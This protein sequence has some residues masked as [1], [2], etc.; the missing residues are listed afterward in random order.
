MKD[1][2][3]FTLL[4]FPQSYDGGTQLNLRLVV[5]PRNQN[6]LRPAIEPV[7][8]GVVP[9]A[10]AQFS[11]AAQII[12]GLNNFPYDQLTHA[13]R[14]LPIVVP[15]IA[16]DLFLALK[17]N[18]KISD[19]DRGNDALETGVKATEAKPPE[20][21]PIMKYLPLSYRQAFNFTTPRIRNAV[22]DDSY[23]CAVRDAAPV[24]GFKRSEDKISWGKVFA[25]ALRQRLLA[26][27]LGMVYDTNV[28]I[29]AADF[30][31]GGWIYVDL[32]A[33]S[34]YRAR[35]QSHPWFIRRY[36]ARIP[37]LK[38]NDDRQIFAPLLFPV[39]FKENPGDPDPDPDGNYDELFIEAA[40]YDDG[41]AKIV[42]ARQPHSRDLLAE[43][44]DGAHPVKDI[45]IR[46][47]WDDEQI[48]I[49]YLR[50]L[51][52]DPSVK[53]PT[54][55]L[56]APLGVFGY[57]VDAREV[58]DPSN[59]WNSLNAVVSKQALVVNTQNDQIPLGDFVGELPYQVYPAQLD[60]N[61]NKSF[62]LPMYFA[63]WNGNSMVLPDEDAANIYHTND[64]VEADPHT[65]VT[66]KAENRLN[67]IYNPGPVDAELKYG[68]LYEFRV[69][70]RDLSGG[71]PEIGAE[72]RNKTPSNT[73]ERRFRRYV[74]PNQPRIADLAANTD[75][76]SQVDELNIRRPL[77]GYPA[78]V[79][80]DGY[81][82]PVAK[83]IAASNAALAARTGHAFGIADP[84]VNRVQVTVE[85][86]TLK[87]DNLLSV[88]G[89]ENYVNLYTTNCFFPPVNNE[90]DF[91]AELNIPIVYRDCPV[92]HT[93]E[94]DKNL[95]VD[96]GLPANI[97]SMAQIVV[98]KGRTIRLTVRAVCEDKPV[99][100]NYYGLLQN[101]DDVK[102]EKDVR[103]GP[104][105]QIMTYK[106][107]E[108]EEDL[109]LDVAGVP[110]L[111]G[112]FMQPDPPQ[113]FDGT[114]VS[115]L[116]GHQ[117][118][119]PPDMIERL[120]KQL[121]LESR[122]LTLTGQK[123]ERVQFGCS[124][125]IRH[126]LSPE[127]SSLTF[128]SKGD[129]MNH[130]LCCISLQIDRDWTWD[131]LEDRAFVIK[132]QKRFTRDEEPAETEFDE[133]GDIEI[134]HT[135]PF[136]ALEDSQRNYTRLVFIDAVEP[137]NPRLQAK[138][139]AP[140]VV[141][142]KPR[143][144]DTIEV[145][146]SIETR[147]K[148][149]HGV[150]NDG[151]ENQGCRLPIT[152]PPAQ[153][154]KIVSAGIAL[155]PYERNPKYSATEPRRRYLWVEFA[156]P[157]D[158]PNDHYFARM[159]AYAPDQLISNNRPELFVAPEEPPLPVEPE[160][161]RSVRSGAT[162]DLA[163]LRAM[164]PMEKAKDSNRHYLLPLPKNLHANA[165]EMFGFFTYEFR[166]GHY[167]DASTPEPED[168]VW[169]TAQGRFGRRLRVTGVQHPAPTLTCMVDR[170]E[171]KVYVSAP[172]AVAVFNGKNV[173]ADPP[174]TQLW[175]L[176]YAQVRQADNRDNRNVLLDDK[177]LDWRV[178]I[179]REK[180]V[181]WFLK[182][183]ER[184]RKTLKHLSI[185]N[186]KDELDYAN[187]KHVLKLTDIE[188]ANKDA[189]KYGTV[190]WTNKEIHQLLDVYGLPG[191][192]PLSVLVVE[193]LPTITSYDDHIR[194]AGQEEMRELLGRVRQEIF[195]SQSN[196]INLTKLSATVGLATVTGATNA[197]SGVTA[198]NALSDTAASGVRGV[199]AG[200]SDPASDYQQRPSP[201]SEALGQVRILRTSPLTE[202]PFI[203]CPD[204]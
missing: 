133:V 5:L 70:L 156:E 68:G 85:V 168:F 201:V 132:R 96:L 19:P 81:A 192:S 40:E 155:S 77:L 151:N 141:P 149:G 78:A 153:V 110:R 62:W 23:R 134:R 176:L 25:Y 158:D 29:N 154:P 95:T 79:Y 50:Q 76:V 121:G 89:K 157:V 142:D 202:V 170:D 31:Q 198:T 180:E 194:P 33:G 101:D 147:F 74:A 145:S 69:R 178:Q 75:T 17:E 124:N 103:F 114:A 128:A 175:C 11:F 57:A 191:D 9:F 38:E 45:G 1:E 150:A 3:R 100:E 129:L 130:W 72:P 204:C 183:N 94:N 21:L 20:Q 173:T 106:E 139:P 148:A 53:D 64:D 108:N 59:P 104:I 71:G 184:E 90:D 125:R 197:A 92:L 26:E 107:S 54:K 97:K 127:N 165:D 177:Q 181:N 15:A 116:L 63:N 112:I 22:T 119:K 82:D 118:E 52:A 126:I 143:F 159:L 91:D 66:G 161:I 203:C 65:G 80:T 51:T 189:T 179:E 41:F 24:P 34:D 61:K 162:N 6:P 115:L 164:Q 35:Q 44:S 56:D 109:F 193:F 18:F 196:L 195:R 166:V 49:W 105:I 99:N 135:A 84:D 102:H 137:K 27:Q 86:Q 13:T 185:N 188:R 144:P 67:A 8:P 174:R 36:A 169:C 167:K 122:G 32:A 111:Q 2:T 163:G 182:Y 113:L 48:L 199:A 37:A 98:P 7:T 146:Y 200:Q 43:E 152:T 83:L 117:V 160:Y 138:P 73:V 88:S 60:G 47:G 172:Y 171:E 42:H 123:G 131:A 120:A 55:R 190:V 136:E 16:K 140:P 14:P 30:A 187:F 58:A 186:W 4:P 93:A 46:L 10:E 39:L 87:M 28:E 12:S